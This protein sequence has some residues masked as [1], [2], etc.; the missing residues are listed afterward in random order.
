[1]D[2][3]R[4]H[5]YKITS[6]ST[7][8]D[9]Q[10]AIT[11]ELIPVLD[12]CYALAQEGKSSSVKV[13][14]EA[15]AKYPANPLL[16]NYLST[17]YMVLGKEEKSYE[18]NHWILTEHS[19]YLFARLNLA[20]EYIQNKE[21]DKVPDVLGELLDIKDLYPER[22]IFHVKEVS[23]YVSTAIRYL[24]AIGDVEQAK[25]R[26]EILE[27]I[28][29]DSIEWE[30]AAELIEYS[31]LAG[32]EDWEG[33][34]YLGAYEVEVK[35]QTKTKKTVSPIFNHPE[36]EMLYTEGLYIGREKLEQ[37]LALPHQTLISDLESILD[38]S[39]GRFSY[40]KKKFDKEW[41]EETSCFVP[42]AVFLLGELKAEESLEAVLN[43]LG[44]S[45]EY[46]DLYLGDFVTSAFWEPIYNMAHN[47]LDKLLPM[48]KSPGINTYAKSLLGDVAAEV[49]LQQPERHDEVLRW[50]KCLF[51]FY[52]SCNADSNI[53]DS[54]LVGLLVWQVLDIRGT[55]ALLEIAQLYDRNIPT[56]GMCGS[57]SEV[58]KSFMNP[59]KA[60]LKKDFLPLADRYEEITKT[61]ASYL[62]EEG[63]LLD[64][65]YEDNEY[66]KRQ[67]PVINETKVG[68]ND[69]CPCG[70]GKKYKKCC[71]NR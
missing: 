64:M 51:N 50:F 36:V 24:C 42:H 67:L 37:L 31:G 4:I 38:D 57:F 60:T 8:L 27:E 13:L 10:N 46:I 5:G 56:Q 43:V 68:R 49:A 32:M 45:D 23:A 48:M 12:K 22:E 71:L 11:P 59:V 34:K 55:E 26:L 1:M 6:D 16:K 28:V 62:E 61:W 25:I 7:F 54:D 69:P 29:P 18:V 47:Q 9:K 19:N 44:Q 15:I 65:D 17:L 53:L 3:T 14:L 2:T 63:N 39:I 52:L 66:E 35:G 40:F 30:Q 41:S 33:E 21:Y 20:N 70:S 58:E